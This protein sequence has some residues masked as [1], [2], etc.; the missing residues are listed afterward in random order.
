MIDSLKI[1]RDMRDWAFS[2]KMTAKKKGPKNFGSH[3][4]GACNE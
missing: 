1:D 4:L 3:P 2:V